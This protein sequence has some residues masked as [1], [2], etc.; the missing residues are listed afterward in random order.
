MYQQRN[1]RDGKAWGGTL[2]AAAILG[3][4][5]IAEPLYAWDSFDSGGPGLLDSL[6]SSGKVLAYVRAG[7]GCTQVYVDAQDVSD[8]DAVPPAAFTYTKTNCLH[9]TSASVGLQ[10]N[11]YF[12]AE[13]GYVNVG[14]FDATAT[15]TEGG[16]PLTETAHYKIKGYQAALVGSWPISKQFDVLGRIGL[17]RWDLHFSSTGIEG[18]VPFSRDESATGTDLT[19]G[20]GVRYNFT[21]SVG[22]S[23]EWQRFNKVGDQTKT[24][25]SDIDMYSLNLIYRFW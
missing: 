7:A 13:I 3:F 8:F 10:L 19:Y 18:G 14:K 16:I 20:L 25:Q 15:G 17:F 21:P 1:V 23:L 2:C 5:G 4:M 12:A 11:R 9:L 24:G 6:Q 22:A